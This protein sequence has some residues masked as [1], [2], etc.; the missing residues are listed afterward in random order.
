M[1]ASYTSSHLPSALQGNPFCEALPPLPEM[2]N[3]MKALLRKPTGDFAS[4][5]A[6]A[7]LRFMEVSSLLDTNFPREESAML[8]LRCL[9]ML[10]NSYG[11]NNPLSTE[12]LRDL[13]GIDEK[14]FQRAS[15]L[16]LQ[17]DASSVLGWSGMGK[18][19]M[20]RTVLEL[21]PQVIQHEIYK[22]RQFVRTQVLYLS[23]DAPIA[24]SPKGLILNIAASLDRALGLV[25]PDSYVSRH[26]SIRM[27]VEAQRVLITRA[28]LAN[29]VG[30]LHVDDLQ[31]LSEGSRTLREAVSAMI[32][33][34]ANTAGCSLLFS[35]TPDALSVLQSNFEVTR[36]ANRRGS[37]VLHPP[38]GDDSEFFKAL[39]IFLFKYQLVDNPVSPDDVLQSHL[40]R[41]TAGIPG[42]LVMLYVAAQETAIVTGRQLTSDFFNDVMRDQ[43]G[44]LQAPIR[45]LNQMRRRGQIKW[46][47]DLD[48]AIALQFRKDAADSVG[49]E[50][51]TLTESV[52]A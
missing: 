44:T 48:Q 3:L 12:S 16:P 10:L 49:N 26:R 5:G 29:G 40:L 14:T 11:R 21:F 45:K 36:R 20:I 43:F 19:T 2:A 47:R 15:S 7:S 41:L 13:Y 27:S 37:F 35:G 38:R 18:T 9:S 22:G 50:T 8:A 24:A 42:V 30:L 51:D 32:I 33:G 34:I 39:V 1:R 46:S 31:R 6:E 4:R 23:I 25:G 52:T 28:L 17:V